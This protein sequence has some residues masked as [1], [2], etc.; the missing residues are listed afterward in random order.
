MQYC[1]RCIYMWTCQTE[2]LTDLQTE[3]LSQ[4]AE[5]PPQRVSSIARIPRTYCYELPGGFAN[6]HCRHVATTCHNSIADMP[7]RILELY[8]W[9]RNYRVVVPTCLS[10]LQLELTRMHPVCSCLSRVFVEHEHTNNA[11]VAKAP[12]SDN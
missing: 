2:L 3:L 1:I 11:C 8:T 12:C 6:L 5:L 4:I 9:H 10:G 7:S